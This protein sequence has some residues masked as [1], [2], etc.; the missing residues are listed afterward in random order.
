M[1][2]ANDKARKSC[3]T[4]SGTGLVEDTTTVCD[5]VWKAVFDSCLEAYEAIQP[6]SSGV[7][8]RGVHLSRP[9]EEFRAD[10]E[11]LGRRALRHSPVLLGT[12]ELYFLDCLD[13]PACCVELGLNH[14]ALYQQI[15][16]I[17]VAC[18]QGFRANGKDGVWPLHT[19]FGTQDYQVPIADEKPIPPVVERI[20]LD[21]EA[22]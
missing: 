6:W 20:L 8:R 13:T 21:E 17:K 3:I 1:K 9:K 5:C 12:F 4:C 7:D 15:C 10:F 2:W 18:G 19:Y 11:L 14:S 22:A 16:R